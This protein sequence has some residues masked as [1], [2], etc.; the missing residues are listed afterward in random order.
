[1]EQ[2]EKLMLQ[3]KE[4][5]EQVEKF[6]KELKLKDELRKKENQEQAIK[7][8][9]ILNAKPLYMQKEEKYKEEEEKSYLDK[10]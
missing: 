5:H 1:M 3:K 7:V 4:K 2:Q 9:E 6:Q 10:Q 8:Q